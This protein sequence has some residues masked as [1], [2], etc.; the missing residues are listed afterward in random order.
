M[1]EEPRYSL[2]S[3]YEACEE[4]ANFAQ[5]FLSL[6]RL[7]FGFARFAIRLLFT[8][9]A[10]STGLIAP[11]YHR[12]LRGSDRLSDFPLPLPFFPVCRLPHDSFSSQ[13]HE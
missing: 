12:Y 3:E 4:R 5:I 9:F 2:L 7:D 10:T 11:Q 1:W 13:L 6:I 8:R